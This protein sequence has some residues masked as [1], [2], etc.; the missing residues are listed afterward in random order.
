[1]GHRNKFWR[2]VQI[3]KL[4]TNQFLQALVTLA[5]LGPAITEAETKHS[6]VNVV[7]LE[8][9]IHAV[10]TFSVKVK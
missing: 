4:L 6:E 5:L 1:M 2:G 8:F 9:C 7:S 10:F 3:M